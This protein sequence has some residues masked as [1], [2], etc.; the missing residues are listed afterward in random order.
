MPTVIGVMSDTH[1]NVQWMHE[2]ADL[3]Q[4]RLGV[5][6]IFHVG[7]DYRDAEQL[8]M[9]GYKVRMVPGLW[10]DAY[11]SP[12]LRWF[13]EHVDDIRIAGCHADKDLRAVDRSADIVLTGHTH[14]ASIEHIANTL[15]VNPGHLKRP[16]DRGQAPSFATIMLDGRAVVAAR[17]HERNGAIRTEYLHPIS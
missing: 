16:V 13:N 17:I 8:E 10:C 14:V 1:G 9:T 3:M 12:K 4:T 2:V 11:R 6:L 15:Y 7:D 5:Q